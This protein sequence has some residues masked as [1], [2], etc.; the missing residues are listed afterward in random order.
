MTIVAGVFVEAESL[1]GCG[2]PA[3]HLEPGYEASRDL[4]DHE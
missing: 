4:I 2:M 1:R 3:A